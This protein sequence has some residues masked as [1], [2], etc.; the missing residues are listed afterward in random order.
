MICEPYKSEL[1]PLWRF[2]TPDAARMSSE[3]I[4]AKF[5]MYLARDDFVGADMA[6]KF[7][8]MG[9]TRSRRYAN[10]KGGRK[11]GANRELLPKGTGD[12]AKAETA[13]IFYKA[14]KCAEV[15][16]VYSSRKTAWKRNV[17]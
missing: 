6:R 15:D 7:L 12:P 16:L 1:L 9:Y 13:E 2:R 3:G 10:Y 14:W 4:L 17:G 8:Q 11:Y 5:K